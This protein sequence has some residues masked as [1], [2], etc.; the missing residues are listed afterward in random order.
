MAYIFAIL[1]LIALGVVVLVVSSNFFNN[2]NG[3]KLAVA[4]VSFVLALIIICMFWFYTNELRLQGI[5]LDYARRF[6]H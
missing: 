1:T 2:N 3:W 6:L 5:Y 4:I